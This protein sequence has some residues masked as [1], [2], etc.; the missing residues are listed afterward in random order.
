MS[1]AGPRSLTLGAI[2]KHVGGTL[3]GSPDVS[4]TGVAGIDEAGSGDLTFVA[5]P[6]YREALRVTRAAGVLVAPDLDAPEGV[7]VIRVDDPYAAMMRVLMLFDPGPPGI[8]D[9]IDASARI[10]GDAELGEGVAVGAHTTVASGARIGRGT[11]LATGVVVEEGAVVGEDCYLY[12]N[13]YVGRHCVLGNR[14][15][16]YP[17][18]VIGS[19]GFGYAPVDGAYVKIPQLGIVVLEDDVEVG[20]NSCIDRATM[21]R[22]W[23]GRGTKI[24]NLVQIAHNVAVAEGGAIAAQSGI[25]GSTR[26]GKRVRLGGQVGISGHLRL[27]DDVSAAAQAGIIEDQPNGVTVAGYPARPTR[28]TWRAVAHLRQ[29]PELVRRVKA[30]ESRSRE[31]EENA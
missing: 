6:K 19:D 11:R 28:E 1:P 24:D 10:A 4:V 20:C 26:V 9:G 12:P 8:P 17:G 3:T 15:V 30:L 22:T 23:I 2:A 31:E 29:L 18:A 16:L 5:H 13:T 21:G 7:A 14:V 27:G 25:A